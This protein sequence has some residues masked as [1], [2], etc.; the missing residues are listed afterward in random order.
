LVVAIMYGPSSGSLSGGPPPPWF[1]LFFPVVWLG[2]TAL[3]AIIGGW[4]G[5]A[6]RFAAREVPV[7]DAFP[8]QSVSLTWFGSYNNAVNVT[9]GPAGVHL[10]PMFLFRLGHKPLLIPWTAVAECTQSGRLLWKRTTLVLRDDG[11]RIR[12][13]GRSGEAILRTWQARQGRPHP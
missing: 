10:V 4:V 12:F 5:L 1:F 11:R 3:F 9:V 8:M 6:E 7:G 13:A 2:V